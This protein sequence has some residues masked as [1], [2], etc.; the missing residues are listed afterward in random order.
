MILS[1]NMISPIKRRISHESRVY[2]K[3]NRLDISGSILSDMSPHIIRYIAREMNG[4][5]IR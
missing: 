5:S 2:D 1:R 4:K 3:A